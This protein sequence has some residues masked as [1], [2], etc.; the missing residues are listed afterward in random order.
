M[1]FLFEFER[2]H[3]R[4][5]LMLEQSLKKWGLTCS[6]Y[7][8]LETLESSVEEKLRPKDLA[9]LLDIDVAASTR[10][11]E[12][13][14]AKKMLHRERCTD[15]RRVC[16]VYLDSEF[17]SEFKLIREHQKRVEMFFLE[18]VD[19]KD[20][21]MFIFAISQLSKIKKYRSGE[22]GLSVIF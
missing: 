16:F 9:E 12:R 21:E 3:S 11:I 15:D 13:L 6:Q 2:V 14:V 1:S 8:L 10:L 22:T 18:G 7:Q 20:R 17:I 5:S 19:V 4:F